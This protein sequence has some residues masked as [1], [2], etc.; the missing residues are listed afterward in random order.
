LK[1]IF[2]IDIATCS[3]CGDDV[4]IISSIE[5]PVVIRKILAHL[6]EK[7]TPAGRGRL[8]EYRAPPATDLL[9]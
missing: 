7:V 6:S 4:K 1:R 2:D 5:D 8:P 3:E 9:V